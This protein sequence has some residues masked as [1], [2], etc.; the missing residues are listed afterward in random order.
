M[1]S[2]MRRAV[3]GAFGLEPLHR[4]NV[5]ILVSLSTTTKIVSFCSDGG[6][7]DVKSIEIEP[8]DSAVEVDIRVSQ[9]T[10]PPDSPR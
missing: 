4:M 9:G 6:K 5:A 8:L 3:C 2:K 7:S 1:L 10:N